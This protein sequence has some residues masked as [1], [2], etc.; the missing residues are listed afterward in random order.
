MPNV[1]RTKE[2]FGDLRF[3]R[4]ANHSISRRAR[5]NGRLC[6]GDSLCGNFLFFSF[7]QKGKEKKRKKVTKKS[8]KKER[9][10]ALNQLHTFLLKR[11]HFS[12]SPRKTF[13][14]LLAPRLP[15]ALEIRFTGL[16]SLISASHA[17]S[18]R[19]VDRSIGKWFIKCVTEEI[20]RRGKG[21]AG[22]RGG[23]EGEKLNWPAVESPR[24]L[25]FVSRP[26]DHVRI[27]LRGN[28]S[29]SYRP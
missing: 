2:L 1:R 10:E 26:T 15:F 4:S 29:R 16:F 28:F 24:L 21:R 7:S 6:H 13:A 20:Q 22:G 25:N 8:E 18:I 19:L 9:K 17:G 12:E 14:K 27:V 23:G 3:N 5:G 11:V